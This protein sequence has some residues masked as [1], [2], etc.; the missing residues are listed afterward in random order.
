MTRIFKFG[1]QNKY[2]L[3]VVWGMIEI[4]G[5]Q[6]SQKAYYAPHLYFGSQYGFWDHFRPIISIVPLITVNICILSLV[7]DCH[8]D[9][10]QNNDP[11][12]I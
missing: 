6:W 12:Q 7:K 1:V 10:L 3:P 9:E 5:P 4:I 8:I 2:W 11:A